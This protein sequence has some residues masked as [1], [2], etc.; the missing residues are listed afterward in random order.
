MVE[1]A[2]ELSK[3]GLE[4]QT[5]PA[6]KTQVLADFIVEMEIKGAEY[7]RPAWTLF[8]DGSSSASGS[9]AEVLLENPQGDKFQY[10]IRLQFS[11]S[12]NEAEYEDIIIGLKLALAAGA[13]RLIAHSDSQL[14][15]NQLQRTYVAKEEKMA[16][17]VLRINK[18]LSNLEKYEVKQVPSAQNEVADR[19]AKMASSMANIDSR[20]VTFLAITK[21]EVEGP[22]LDILCAGEG[23]PSWK[24]EIISFLMQGRLP[25]DPSIAR[26]L[27]IRAARFTIIDNELYKRG[28]SLPYLKCLAPSNANYVL[29]EIHE[30]VCGNHLGGR[31]LAEKA[32]RQGYFWPTMRRDAEKLVRHCH[33]CQ[34]HTNINHQ[35]TTLLQPLESPLPFVQWGMDIVGPFPIASGQRKFIL[36]AVDYFTKW[37]EAEP[38]AKIAERDIINFVWKNIIRN[39]QE[40]GQTEV[41]NRTILQ[42]LKTRL[43]AAKGKWVDELSSALW[44]Y[45]TTSRTSTGESPF[46]MVYGAEAVAPAEIGEPSMRVQNYTLADIEKAMRLSLD[47]V[48][49][50]REEA[51]LRAERWQSANGQ[52]VQ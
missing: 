36:V 13:R 43:G 14:V 44:A 48:D 5:R 18:L 2:V 26:K 12:N 34:D 3:Y 45:R 27:R 46:N 38:L 41:T 17:C 29:Q 37:V 11:T 35:P 50:L 19:L 7:S 28:Y 33:A 20:K 31:A 23:E 10:S 39:P 8:V 40:N 24:D 21:E 49:E 47:L 52:S 6:V 9:G 15:V 42:H 16:K 1:W 32:L 30:G 4:Y 51:S 22:T 25:Q